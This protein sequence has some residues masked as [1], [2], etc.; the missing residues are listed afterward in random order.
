MA[1]L[2]LMPAVNAFAKVDIAQIDFTKA[3]TVGSIGSTDKQTLF[4]LN[5]T[6]YL[7]LK[8]P[9]PLKKTWDAFLD[10]TDISFKWNAPGPGGFEKMDSS[11]N[12]FTMGDEYWISDP[13]WDQDKAVGKWHIKNIA[14]SFLD[15]GTTLQQGEFQGSGPNH[16]LSFTV[17]PEPAAEALFL[18]GAGVLALVVFRGRKKV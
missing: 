12:A 10:T 13:N 16:R 14:Y 3:Y 17:T 18:F 9:D 2:F 7:Y 1:V 15:D 5:E 8:L 4:G 11:G 6:P